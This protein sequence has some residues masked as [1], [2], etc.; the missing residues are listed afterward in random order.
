MN[1]AKHYLFTKDNLYVFVID[2]ILL[3]LQTYLQSSV[4]EASSFRN[5]KHKFPNKFCKRGYPRY[6]GYAP[7]ISFDIVCYKDVKATLLF[8][9]QTLMNIYWT[10]K[11]VFNHLTFVVTSYSLVNRS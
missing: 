8:F 3:E 6:Q 10:C 7:I 4:A 1:W 11:L 2:C 5:I 9:C